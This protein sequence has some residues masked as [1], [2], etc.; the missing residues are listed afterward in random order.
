MSKIIEIDDLEFRWQRNQEPLL[1]FSQ[2]EIQ[3][4]S[5]VFL[6][7]PS[8]SGK[9]TFLNLI[10]GMLQPTQGEIRFLDFSLTQASPKQRDQIRGDHIGYIFQLFNLVP[11]LNL[12]ENIL[13]PLR[14]SPKRKKKV[15]AESKNQPEAEARRLTHSLKI[16]EKILDQK[17]AEISVGQAQR[18]AAARALIGAPELIIADEPTSA[19]DQDNQRSFCELLFKEVER[20]GSSLLFVSHDDRLKEGFEEVI[21]L[22]DLNT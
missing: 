8:G 4:K 10:A 18:V 15:L 3:E 5:T 17:A 12:I 20:S 13:L 14:F 21:Q 11:Y 16:P 19:L 2:F 6:Q 9:S 22:K 7:G 1:K